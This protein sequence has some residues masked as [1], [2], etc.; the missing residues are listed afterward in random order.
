MGQHYFVTDWPTSIRPYYA[1][2]YEDDP[3]ICRAFDLMHPRMELSSGAQRVHRYDMLEQQLVAKGLDP[4]SFE[5]YLRP[6]RYGMPPHAGWGLG[7]ERFVMTML[8]L[9]ERPRGRALSARPAPARAMT[10]PPV[11]LP[12]TVVGSYPPVEG[13]GLRSLLDRHRTALETAVADQLR[14]GVEIISDGQVRADMVSAFAAQLPGVREG[15]VIGR[16]GPPAHAITVEDVRYARSKAPYVKGIL[17]GPTTL[18]HALHLDTH[19]YRDK[20]ELALDLAAVLAAE[21]RAL[22]GAGVCMLQIDEPILS[23]GAADPGTAADGRRPGRRGPPGAG[24]APRLRADRGDDRRPAAIPG[25]DPRPRVRGPSREPRGAGRARARGE[26][27]RVRRGRLVLG[28]GRERSR[29]SAPGS[30][31]ASRSSARNGS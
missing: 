13:R 20:E 5:F 14:A 25:P 2:P 4:A 16:I 10:L 6:F 18:A 28:R 12:T 15:R 30:S 26:A 21:A 19:V 8:D 22:A 17:T 27:D 24:R 9:A 23:T 7:V 3:S 31:A 1:L 11:L 29:P